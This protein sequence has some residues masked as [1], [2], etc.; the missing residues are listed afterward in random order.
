MSAEWLYALSQKLT[1]GHGS[2]TLHYSPGVKQGGKNWQCTVRV[3]GPRRPNPW[4]TTW[5][6]FP[7]DAVH[8]AAMHVRRFAEDNDPEALQ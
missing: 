6:R 5:G 4:V 2:I 3:K 8:L 1:G 7:E